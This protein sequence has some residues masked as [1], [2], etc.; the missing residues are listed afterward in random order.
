MEK[1]RPSLSQAVV[2]AA[3]LVLAT[4]GM[5]IAAPSSSS[6]APALRRQAPPPVQLAQSGG[7]LQP[8]YEPTPPPPPK[9][10]NGQYIFGITRSVADAPMAPAAKIFLFPLTVPFDIVFFPFEVIAGFF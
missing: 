8:R 7:E 2:A 10:F 1:P 9:S 3:L 5:S 4:T 6:A